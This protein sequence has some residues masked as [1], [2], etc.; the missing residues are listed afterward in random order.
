MEKGVPT[1]GLWG[2][3]AVATGAEGLWPAEASGKDSFRVG[4]RV[5]ADPPLL[6]TQAAAGTPTSGCSAGHCGIKTVARPLRRQPGCWGRGWHCQAECSQPPSACLPTWG[7]YLAAWPGGEGASMGPAHSRLCS[8]RICLLAAAGGSR[9][10]AAVMQGEWEWGLGEPVAG[11][12]V[13]SAVCPLCSVGCRQ[14]GRGV[15]CG[16]GEQC[17]PCS[18]PQTL[19]PGQP[20]AVS[21]ISAPP[22]SEDRCPLPSL[23]WPMSTGQG[24]AAS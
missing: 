16:P 6:C 1:A 24:W 17:S 2:A 12:G 21:S 22:C 23:R 10:G 13:A 9:P 3:E 20:W 18:G 8:G 4:G 11:S 7:W 15:C 19:P 5:A 14:G